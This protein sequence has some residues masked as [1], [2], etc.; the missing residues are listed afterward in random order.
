MDITQRQG[1]NYLREGKFL[2]PFFRR[3]IF[4]RYCS[5]ISLHEMKRERFNYEFSGKYHLE[6]IYQKNQPEKEI[7]LSDPDKWRAK[8]FFFIHRIFPENN[9][10]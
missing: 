7:T 6:W 2:L 10:L 4:S 3:P 9:F 5:T 8:K 1:E